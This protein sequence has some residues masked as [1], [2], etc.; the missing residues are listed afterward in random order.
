MLARHAQP[1][2]LYDPMTAIYQGLGYAPMGYPVAPVPF[3]LMNLASYPVPTARDLFLA[4]L[5]MDSCP[6]TN[7]VQ[8]FRLDAFEGTWYQQAIN[9]DAQK[10]QGGECVKA[11]YTDNG[12]GNVHVYNSQQK[13]D[14]F[15]NLKPR[16]SITGLARPANN[17]HDGHLKVRLTGMPFEGNYDVL[18]TDYTS[19]A[20]IYA[21][22]EYA[23]MKSE[24]AW[25]LTRQPNPVLDPVFDQARYEYSKVGIDFDN[26]FELT[27]QG[28][29]AGC[30]YSH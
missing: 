24:L 14:Q 25:V 19:Y 30:N 27:M 28:G 23:G 9:H 6:A 2:T 16:T 11:E 8:N 18:K 4:N 5:D 17:N 15:G 29:A 1:Q 7:V 12:D 21:C 20:I 22:D 10:Q 3:G 13:K 26:E